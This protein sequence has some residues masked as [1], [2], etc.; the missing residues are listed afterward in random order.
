MASHHN[1]NLFFA[2][3]G[4]LHKKFESLAFGMWAW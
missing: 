2:Q 4:N 1:L 3:L